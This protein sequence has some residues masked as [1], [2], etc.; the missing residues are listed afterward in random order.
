MAGDRLRSF[1]APRGVAFATAPTI[2]VVVAGRWA[3]RAARDRCVGMYVATVVGAMPV[4]RRCV[5][6]LDVSNGRGH[7][8]G[9]VVGSTSRI[10]KD[11]NPSAGWRPP[12]SL[13][14]ARR[15]RRALR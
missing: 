13:R 1:R 2:W 10:E 4:P 12:P 14:L 5:V 11:V 7:R 15:P 6:S 3:E 8:L 9:G